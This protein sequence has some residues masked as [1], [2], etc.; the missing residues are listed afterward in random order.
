MRT[1]MD[2]AVLDRHFRAAGSLLVK[3]ADGSRLRR[4]RAYLE[5]I[6]SVLADL[7]ANAEV[8]NY[9]AGQLGRVRD[10]LSGH[11]EAAAAMQDIELPD[12]TVAGILQRGVSAAR[13]GIEAISDRT[14]QGDAGCG[15]DTDEVLPLL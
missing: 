1:V 14:S 2:F 15:Y 6:D 12:Q 13:M 7:V 3:P 9:V 11:L 4:A 10:D 5:E 8:T